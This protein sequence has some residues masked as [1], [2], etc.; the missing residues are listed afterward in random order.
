MITG[1]RAPRDVQRKIGRAGGSNLYGWPNYRLVWGWSRLQL[2]G[3]TPADPW[4][5]RDEEGYII[6]ESRGYRWVPKYWMQGLERWHIER[7]VPPEQCAGT[8]EQWRELYEPE[9]GPYPS[10]GEYEHSF[11]LP[12]MYGWDLNVEAVSFMVRQVERSRELV[13]SDQAKAKAAIQEEQERKNQEWRDYADEVTR[14]AMSAF[15]G[16]AVTVPELPSYKKKA[17]LYLP[18]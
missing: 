1:R 6:R 12:R 17:G 10:Q 13:W 18:N 3:A 7:W 4:V 2:V 16:P 8:P 15:N 9:L 5:D 14:E 11:T